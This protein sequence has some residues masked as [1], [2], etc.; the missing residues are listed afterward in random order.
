MTNE[1]MK[2]REAVGK[3]VHEMLSRANITAYLDM[4]DDTADK[5]AVAV[6]EHLKEGR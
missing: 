1:A 5:I 3:I 2:E 6:I 4:P